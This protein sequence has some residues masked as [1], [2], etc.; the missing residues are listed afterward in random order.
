[1]PGLKQ[2]NDGGLNSPRAAGVAGVGKGNNMGMGDDSPREGDGREGWKAGAE[3]NQP[4]GLMDVPFEQLKHI[5]M[6]G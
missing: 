3:L 1:M 4:G 2:G 6:F 5:M